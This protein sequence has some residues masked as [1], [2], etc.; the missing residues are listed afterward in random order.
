[1]NID[2]LGNSP[3]TSNE[4]RKCWRCMPLKPDL[5]SADPRE[6]AGSSASR[7]IWAPEDLFEVALSGGWE[8]VGELLDLF[9]EDTASRLNALK[10]AIV[11]ADAPLIRNDAH[12]IKGSAAQVGARTLADLCRQMEHLA[13]QGRVAGL[14]SLLAQIETEFTRACRL[15]SQANWNEIRAHAGIP[16]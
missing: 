1:M 8:L 12:A 3:K 16:D 13:A 7:N 9:Q 10:Q 6:P 4:G 15:M 2:P 14:E 5:K 11:R